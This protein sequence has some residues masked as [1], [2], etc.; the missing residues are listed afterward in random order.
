MTL[1][2]FSKGFNPD[3]SPRIFFAGKAKL[4]MERRGTDVS[5]SILFQ[6]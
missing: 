6:L 4:K 1:Q 5:L 3:Y 2:A